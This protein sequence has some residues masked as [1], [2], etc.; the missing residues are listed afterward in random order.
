M[1]K[2]HLFLKDAVGKRKNRV[3]RDPGEENSTIKSLDGNKL[4]F[5]KIPPVVKMKE[6]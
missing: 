5:Q 6:S 4:I 1:P 3:F 2:N